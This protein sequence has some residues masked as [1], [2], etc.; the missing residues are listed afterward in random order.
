[1]QMVNDLAG[2]R[3]PHS[4]QAQRVP[5]TN[6]FL[7]RCP[8]GTRGYI[9][10]TLRHPKINDSFGVARVQMVNDLAGGRPPAASRPSG[11]PGQIVSSG[12]V[13]LEPAGTFRKPCGTR[14]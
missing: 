10:E 5:G 7:G 14:K 3:P 11:S 6:C 1:M 2:G 9:S 4:E 13:P 12:A 8:P